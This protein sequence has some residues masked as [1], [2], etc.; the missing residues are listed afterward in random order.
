VQHWLIATLEGAF[1]GLALYLCVRLRMYLGPLIVK[2]FGQG[3]RRAYWL[4]TIL[5][6]ILLSNLGLYVFRLYLGSQFF[7]DETLMLEFW[8]AILALAVGV[9]LV[10]MKISRNASA[11]KDSGHQT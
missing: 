8:F 3:A 10:F 9:G 4:L 1:L 7:G 11:A 2:R 6:M 5:L